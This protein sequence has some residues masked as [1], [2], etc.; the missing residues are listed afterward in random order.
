MRARL[1]AFLA[2]DTATALPL[3]AAMLLALALAN[4]LHGRSVE[5][6]LHLEIGVGIAGLDLVKPVVRWANDGLMAIFFLL[7]GMEIK[8]EVAEGE[9][10]QPS[11]VALPIAGAMGGI[12][13]TMSLFIGALTF[14]ANGHESLVRFGV[15]G[16]STLSAVAGYIVL[17]VSSRRR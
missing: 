14:E 17:D 11:N 16:A 8:R 2:G 1:R 12:G 6:L 10:S 13:F 3:F 9:L 15:L 4:S 7:V 5:S